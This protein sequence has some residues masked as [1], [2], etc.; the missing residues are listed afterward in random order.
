MIF[1][2]QIILI[3]LLLAFG[4]SPSENY[5]QGKKQDETNIKFIS[6]VTIICLFIV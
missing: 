3:I 6:V 1:Q 4:Q 2:N 5:T